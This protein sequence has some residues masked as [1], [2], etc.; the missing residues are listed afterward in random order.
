M[1]D[2]TP[3]QTFATLA[4]S[5]YLESLHALAKCMCATFWW[6]PDVQ[7]AGISHNGTVSFVD[8]GDRLLALTNH[9]VVKQYLDDRAADTTIKCQFGN[10]S[11][12]PASRV[13]GADSGLDLAAIDVSSVVVAG[14]GSSVHTSVSWPPKELME[15]EVVILGGYPGQLRVPGKDSVEFSF[16]SFLGQVTS[17]SPE[18]INISLDLAQAQWSPGPPPVPDFNPGGASG[19]PIFRVKSG[20]IE[21]L[22]LA[23]LIYQY[24]PVLEVVQGQHLSRVTGLGAIFP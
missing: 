17:S 23:G 6:Y 24:G 14:T 3:E 10:M 9:H 11:F 18:R 15:G 16:V 13:L 5:G 21:T 1:T 2:L 20:P 22:E 19:G 4:K 8:T 7:G 12:E